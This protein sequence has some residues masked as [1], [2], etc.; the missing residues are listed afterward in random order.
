MP[1]KV[2]LVD[3]SPTELKLMSAMLCD[4]G[5]RLLTAS[6]GEEALQK[7]A[8]HKPDV[9]LLDVILPKKN[10][11]QVVRQIRTTPSVQSVR[12]VMVSSRSQ[13]PDRLWGLMQGADD[14][15]CKPFTAE[16]LLA[17]IGQDACTTPEN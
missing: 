13:G 9:V 11:F 5:Y 10:G 6:D 2:L 14:Y 8:K 7:V 4:K 1:T 12:I 15:L 16:Q 17:S 3:D